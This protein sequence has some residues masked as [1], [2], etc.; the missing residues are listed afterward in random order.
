M[1]PLGILLG[2]LPCLSSTLAPAQ[3]APSPAEG[4]PA[5][6]TYEGRAAPPTSAGRK[7]EG[8]TLTPGLEVFAQYAYRRTETQ[9]AAGASSS[10]W[11]HEFD[12][13]RVHLSLTAETDQVMGR[14]LVEAVRSAENGALVGVSGDSLVARLREGYGGYRGVSWLEVNAGLIPTLTLPELEGTWMLRAVGAAPQEEAGLL[15]PADIGGSAR[16]LLPGSGP[17]ADS[18][19]G[20]IGA[21]AYNGEGYT[22]RELNRGKNFELAASIHPV[23][24]GMLRALAMFAGYTKGSKGTGLSRS[25]RATGALLWQGTFLRAGA[26]F[27]YA[28]GLRDS[29]STRSWMIDG[30]ANL[31]PWKGLI[32]AL[33]ASNWRRSTATDDSILSLTGAV[34]WEFDPALQTFLAVTRSLP[35]DDAQAALPDSDYLEARA[36]ARVAF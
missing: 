24:S 3:T 1:R 33:R 6:P 2:L 7:L 5:A 18:S 11:I 28:W 17:E 36:V 25:D 23:S 31:T 19:Y 29:G 13:P 12:V 20:W 30:F 22:N 4:A 21:A 8:V 15:S 10:E 27:T 32:A 35:S 34:G 16:V 9:D 14:V 26:G